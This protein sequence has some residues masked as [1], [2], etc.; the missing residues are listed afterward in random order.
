MG[1]RKE[2]PGA[3]IFDFRSLNTLFAWLIS[4]Q[5]AVLFS[6]NKPAISNQTAVLFSQNKP[7]P[8][9]SHQPTEHA[10]NRSGLQ[11]TRGSLQE[12]FWQGCARSCEEQGDWLD[13]DKATR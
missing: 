6:Q 3:T 10:V 9:I 1:S 8:A 4:H 7:A 12:A 11:V 2:S 5:P 13:A